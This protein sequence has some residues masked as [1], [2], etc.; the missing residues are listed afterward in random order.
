MGQVCWEM[1][2]VQVGGPIW[3]RHSRDSSLLQPLLVSRLGR[4]RIDADRQP[5]NAG[6]KLSR[7]HGAGGT[8]HLLGHGSRQRLLEVKCLIDDDP[9]PW[10]VDPPGI[11]SHPNLGESL[12]HEPGE[13]ELG[14]GG[15]P[16]EVQCGTY[17]HCRRV[18][19]LGEIEL[20]SHQLGR[21]VGDSHHVRIERRLKVGDEAGIGLHH[22]HSIEPRE[23]PPVDGLEEGGQLGVRRHLCQPLRQS[24]RFE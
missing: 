17:L 10:G 14:L 23:S 16:G 3:V 20:I 11:Q 2:S 18:L 24:P 1:K 8:E 5:G 22:E 7:G 15:A 9:S 12:A 19:D 4:C 13:L 21:R 6:P